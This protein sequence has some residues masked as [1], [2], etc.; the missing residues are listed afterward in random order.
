MLPVPTYI[1]ISQSY[2]TS[3]AFS[4][5]CETTDMGWC[6]TRYACLLPQL[7]PGTHSSLT[8]EG[9]LELSRPGCLV[10][11]RGGLLIQRRSPT[12]ALTGPS[13]E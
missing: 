7:S 1:L 5:H 6:I 3:Q 12:Q 2:S 13:V 10:L 9:G 11:R 4:E 8:T